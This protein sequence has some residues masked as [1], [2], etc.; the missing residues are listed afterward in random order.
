MTDLPSTARLALP[1]LAMAQ[2][3]KE[4]THNEALTLLDLLVQPVVEAGPQATPC[5][6]AGPRTGL[7]RRRGRFRGVGRRGWRAGSVDRAAAG[8]S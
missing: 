4:V 7:D 5:G 6:D 1:L 8:V 3:Q 2:A